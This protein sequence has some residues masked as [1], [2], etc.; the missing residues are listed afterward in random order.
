MAALSDPQ[1]APLTDAH[2]YASVKDMIVKLRDSTLRPAAVPI[3]AR[4]LGVMKLLP[5][6]QASKYLATMDTREI[7]ARSLEKVVEQ[8]EI[9]T[10]LRKEAPKKVVRDHIELDLNPRGVY[11]K[12]RGENNIES[13][14]RDG[15]PLSVNILLSITPGAVALFEESLGLEITGVLHKMIDNYNVMHGLGGCLEGAP[16]ATCLLRA[17]RGGNLSV[18]RAA[19]TRQPR[20]D[21]PEL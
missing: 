1:I 14:I 11:E 10:G 4:G 2:Q 8:Y 17:A 9:S 7:L 3:I 5:T 18:V 12:L 21:S 16:P 20:E 6:P 19:L 15:F 13:L